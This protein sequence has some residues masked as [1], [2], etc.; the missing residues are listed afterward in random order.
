MSAVIVEILQDVADDRQDPEWANR[1]EAWA[2]RQDDPMRALSNIA[3]AGVLLAA[4]VLI[5][6]EGGDALPAYLGHARKHWPGV[7]N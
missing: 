2:M 3:V 4:S 6:S 1:V 7:T 5:D